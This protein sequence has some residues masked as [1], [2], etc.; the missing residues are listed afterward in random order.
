MAEHARQFREAASAPGAPKDLSSAAFMSCIHSP[1]FRSNDLVENT[2]C[3][4]L[5]ITLGLGTNYLKAVE[6]R[7]AERDSEWALNVADGELIASWH[8]AQGELFA[9]REA[10]EAATLDVRSKERGREGER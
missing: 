4:P 8:D 3:T 7:C 1:L 5:H 10:L 9:A 2:T 6:A